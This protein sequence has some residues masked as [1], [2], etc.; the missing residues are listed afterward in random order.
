[1][2]D[3]QQLRPVTVTLQCNRPDLDLLDG[4]HG[5]LFHGFVTE[6]NQGEADGLYT[7]AIVEFSNGHVS[8]F[9]LSLV[10]FVDSAQWVFPKSQQEVSQ[11]HD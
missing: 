6:G 9:D 5:G 8:T 3:R 2:I 4:L 10:Q 11:Q 7:M 1:M